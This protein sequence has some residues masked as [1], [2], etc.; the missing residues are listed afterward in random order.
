[1]TRTLRELQASFVRLVPD[2]ELP[3]EQQGHQVW[4]RIGDDRLH[5]DGVDFLCPVCFE[6]N[7][8]V[9][10]THGIVCWFPHVSQAIHPGPGRWEPR[11]PAT[12]DNLTFVPYGKP[13]SSSALYQSVRVGSHAHFAVENGTVRMLEG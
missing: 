11:I 9:E 8:G 5:A 4:E 1:M 10:G 2:A 12:L 6:K 7:G 3:P 13:G